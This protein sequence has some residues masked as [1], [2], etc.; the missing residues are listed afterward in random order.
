MK[1]VAFIFHT[2]PH[3]TSS[4][5]EGLDAIL[6]A[7]AYSEELAI[8]FVGEGV[9]QLLN[10]QDPSQV[11]SRDYISA[12]K[13]LDLYDIEQRYICEQSLQDWGLGASDL[14]IDGKIV[15]PQQIAQQW[16][17]FDQLLTF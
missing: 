7:S 4:A 5:R 13:L 9:L 11:L 1:K 14:I 17:E 8:F 3:G 12:F 15:S 2:A 10:G 16:N 6:A